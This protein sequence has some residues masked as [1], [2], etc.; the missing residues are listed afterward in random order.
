VKTVFVYNPKSGSALS[1]SELE[2]LTMSAGVEIDIWLPIT[3]QFSKKLAALCKKPIRVLAYGGDGTIS[4]TAG[5][6]ADTSSVL[7]PLPGGTLNHFSKDLGVPQDMETALSE[8]H[9]WAQQKIDIASVNDHYFINNSS[10]G[11]YARSLETRDQLSGKIAKWPAAAWATLKEV[12]QFRTYKIQLNNKWHRTPLM[13]VG[14]NHYSLS[15]GKLGVRH[16]VNT[17]KLSIYIAKASSRL[18][19]FRIG[20]GLLMGKKADLIEEKS[21]ESIIRFKNKQVIVSVDGEK[22]RMTT[23]LTYRIHP[24]ALN[25]LTPK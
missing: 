23:P 7:V 8:L 14:N 4:S 10:I 9:T 17:G 2:K 22:I 3:A 18:A 13:F 25:V 6:L 12:I 19:I 5:I 16:K 24:G 11:V 15:S 20:I 21:V 1:K